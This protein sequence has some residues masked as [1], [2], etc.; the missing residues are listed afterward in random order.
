MSTVEDLQKAAKH[1]WEQT[2]DMFIEQLRERDNQIVGL[3][4]EIEGLKADKPPTEAQESLHELLMLLESDIAWKEQAQE[5]TGK[6]WDD[7]M[8]RLIE[9]FRK[10]KP[11]APT[12]SKEAKDGL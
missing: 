5:R 7:R 11:K 9:L 3:K 4:E 8:T 6:G 1:S 12:K 10:L 2:L